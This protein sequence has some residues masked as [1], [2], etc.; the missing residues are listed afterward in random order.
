MRDKRLQARPDHEDYGTARH[1]LVRGTIST[2]HLHTRGTSGGSAQSPCSGREYFIPSKKLRYAGLIDE[3]P[4]FGRADFNAPIGA[5]STIV[6]HQ[7][8]AAERNRACAR[9]RR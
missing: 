6:S 2:A 3:V 7:N 9:G 5:T 4:A 1:L 8:L